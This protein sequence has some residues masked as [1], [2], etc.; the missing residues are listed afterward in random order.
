MKVEKGFT[1]V[2]LIVVIVILGILA[3]MA[4]PRFFDFTSQTRKNSLNGLRGAM[5]SAAHLI[6]ARAAIEG[7]TNS[8]IADNV[9]VEGVHLVYGYPTATPDGILKA[10][11]LQK[12]T[13]LVNNSDWVYHHATGLIYITHAS[14]KKEGAAIQAT[15]C[16]AFYRAAESPGA[17]PEVGVRLD[18]C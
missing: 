3:V 12:S 9:Y 4:A 2:E 1:L 18:H 13:T 5:E 8:I 15:D 14:F 10:V 6:N 11:E 7:K 17:T 16:Y